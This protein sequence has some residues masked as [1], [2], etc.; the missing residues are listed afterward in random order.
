MRVCDNCWS[1]KGL[2]QVTVDYLEHV[3]ADPRRENVR[4]SLWKTTEVPDLCAECLAF[5]KRKDFKGIAERSQ[6]SLLQRLGI[7]DDPD[8]P[9]SD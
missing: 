7:P 5:L 6:T 3:K 1:T 8:L 9:V 2:A 4:T